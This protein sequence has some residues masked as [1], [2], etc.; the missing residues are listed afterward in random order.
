MNRDGGLA[1]RPGLVQSPP[2]DRKRPQ[3]TEDLGLLPA[4]AARSRMRERLL[5]PEARFVGAADADR[6]LRLAHAHLVA[7]RLVEPGWRRHL[8]P[9]RRGERERAAQHEYGR[10]RPIGCRRRRRVAARQRAPARGDDV[11]ELAL[12]RTLPRRRAVDRERI[13]R[14]VGAEG[15]EVRAVPLLR[16]PLDGAAIRPRR[17]G[18]VVAD[19]EVHAEVRLVVGVRSCPAGIDGAA[20]SCRR[21]TARR[22]SPPARR[23]TPT[24]RAPLR[25]RRA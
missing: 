10:R 7:R 4:I 24:G 23:P 17:R 1:E 25:R 21:A 11:V 6:G 19:A 13:D 2:R 14:R 12:Q 9:Q 15:G 22:P 18:G 5:E 8:R 20:G 16:G 3:P